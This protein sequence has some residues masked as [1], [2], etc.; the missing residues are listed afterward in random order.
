MFKEKMPAPFLLKVSDSL[1]K[2]VKPIETGF[3]QDA[4]IVRRKVFRKRKYAKGSAHL[5]KEADI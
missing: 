1:E 4:A 5:K 2:R 3:V